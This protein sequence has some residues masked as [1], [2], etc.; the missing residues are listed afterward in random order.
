[1]EPLICF[2]CNFGHQMAPIASIANLA[3][4]WCHKQCTLPITG[5]LA[6]S[7]GIELVSS[8]KRVTSIKSQQG[9]WPTNN[10]DPNILPIKCT[11]IVFLWEFKCIS[12]QQKLQNYDAKWKLNNILRY[13]RHAYWHKSYLN[14]YFSLFL[15]Q[16]SRWNA[17]IK[18]PK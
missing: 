3:M 14:I 15:I 8:L 18:E 4:S 2:D 6:S 16:R 11:W 1:M 13:C 17:L 7:V 9:V 12:V 5:L 10:M